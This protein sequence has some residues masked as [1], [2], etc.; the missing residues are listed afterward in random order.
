[1][2]GYVGRQRGNQ[3]YAGL[4]VKKLVRDTI[5]T[6]TA[7]AGGGKANAV[8]LRYGFNRISVCATIGDSVLLPAAVPGAECY[9]VHDGAT[10]A[11]VFGQGTD[12][13]DSVITATGVTMTQAKRAMFVCET[14][15]AWQSFA[16]AK[17]T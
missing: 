2:V 12:T 13:V 14:L 15:G 3:I 11:Q 16:G 9:I 10:A 5:D 1:M 6:I 4:L 17:I 8:P 7:H